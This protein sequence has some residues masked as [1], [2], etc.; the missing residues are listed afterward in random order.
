MRFLRMARDGNP[1]P[2]G[3]V[4]EDAVL[5]LIRREGHGDAKAALKVLMRE[6]KQARDRARVAEDELKK[7]KDGSRIAP[8]GGVVLTAEDAKKW[9]TLSKHLTDSK[10]TPEQLIEA[11]G[12]VGDLEGKLAATER[13]EL[14]NSVAD[15]LGWNGSALADVLELKK[16]TVAMRDVMVKDEDTGKS[17]KKS[18]PHV[19]AADDEKASWELLETY[20]E[21]NLKTF[22]PSL[23][24]IEETEEGTDTQRA[25]QQRMKGT[26]SG[27]ATGGTKVPDQ[28]RSKP[29]KGGADKTEEQ[30][31]KENLETNNYAAL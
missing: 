19:R 1:A 26:G 9:A 7:L 18:L 11:A 24:A 3:G 10:L 22:L 2:S 29:A 12:K 6:N 31:R 8:E 14:F 17:V 4:S 5:R 21:T 23:T 25:P 30:I 28:S 16:L 15:E 27:A 13:K 20:A